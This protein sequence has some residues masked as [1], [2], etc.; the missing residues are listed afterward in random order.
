[1]SGEF[2]FDLKKILWEFDRWAYLP[3]KK[4]VKNADVVKQVVF[5]STK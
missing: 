4:I 3:V 1:M 2:S 5:I